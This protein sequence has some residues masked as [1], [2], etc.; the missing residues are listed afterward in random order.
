MTIITWSINT[1]LLLLAADF[2]FT[3]VIDS[4]TDVTFTRIGAVYPDGVKVVIRYPLYHANET[5]RDVLILWCSVTSAASAE[6]WS[7]GPTLRLDPEFDWT[8]TTKLTKLWPSTEYECAYYSCPHY[9]INNYRLVRPPSRY[10]GTYKQVS[11]A[12][13]ERKRWSESSTLSRSRSLLVR[14]ILRSRTST[15]SYRTRLFTS[16]PKRSPAHLACSLS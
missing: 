3:P 15:R 13:R 7:D 4:A 2:V 10:L 1:F 11:P 12:V 16:P 14:R 8:N 9:K 6:P 5:G